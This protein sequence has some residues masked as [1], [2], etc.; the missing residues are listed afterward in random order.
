[1]PKFESP[2]SSKQINSPPMKDF[3]V[4]DESGFN[5]PP[6]PPPHRH[7]QETQPPPFDPVA[8][9]EFEASMQPQRA[10]LP[11]KEMSDIERQIFE[12]KKAKR[13]GKERLSDGAKRRIEMLIGM[14]R[15]T[16]TVDIE[17]NNFS[18]QTLQNREAREALVAA[19]DYDG[20]VQFSFE[21]S[22]QLLARSLTQIAGISFSDFISSHDLEDK[23]NF[24]EDLPQAL[25]TRLYNEYVALDDES[26][27]KFSPKTEN[28][29]KEVVEDLKK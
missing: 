17:G 1:M 10:P 24:V 16:K 2:I 19:A 21:Y 26:R 7:V 25:F 11:M 5:P 4:P 27:A 9:R 28:Q 14:T 23:L 13:E 22:K 8:M 12:A 18:L 20:T 29:V 15:M 3:R 6:P